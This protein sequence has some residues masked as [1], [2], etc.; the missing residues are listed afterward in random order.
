[1]DATTPPPAGRPAAVIGIDP[2]L[3]GGLAALG[4]AGEVLLTRR[5]P[6]TRGARGELDAPGVLE[7]LR[8]L[9]DRHAVALVV[10]ERVGARP[11]QGSASTFKFGHTA[12]RLQGLVEALG[13]PLILAT[14][15]AWMGAVLAGLPKDRDRVKQATIQYCKRRWPGADLRGSAAAGARESD[16]ICD[17][18]AL[19]EYGRRQVFG[20]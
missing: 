18:L 11:A 6:V 2:G 12:G 14:P 9:A 7:V 4:P 5:M 15:Q 3:S 17:A 1:M 8:G 19:A 20:T 13:F 16:G 10:L